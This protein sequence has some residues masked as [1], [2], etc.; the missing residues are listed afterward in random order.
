MRRSEWFRHL[1]VT[2][3]VAWTL[4]ILLIWEF[5]IF[6]IG[7]YELRSF[8]SRFQARGPTPPDPRIVLIGID[9]S[10]VL[11]DTDEDEIRDNPGY[12]WLR[13][14]PY[15]RKTYAAALKKL[16]D[17]GAKVVVF[18]LLF[19]K[20]S[21]MDDGTPEGKRLAEVDDAEFRKALEKYHDRVVIGA[22]FTYGDLGGNVA[23]AHLTMWP[24][25]NILPGGSVPNEEVV[26]FVNYVEEGDGVIR[27][28]HPVGWHPP[29]WGN[30]GDEIPYS[31]DA[32]AVKKAFPD[33]LLPKKDEQRYILFAGPNN[34]YPPVPFHLLFNTKAWKE[35]RPPLYG[36]K[37]F[38]DKIVLIGPR[39][40]FMHDD[41]F[42]PFGIGGYNKM[43]GVDIHAH[44]MAT[45]LSKNHLRELKKWQSMAVITAMG[46]L[47]GFL[48]NLPKGPL[49]KLAPAFVVGLSYWGVIQLLFEKAFLFIPFIPVEALIVG[50][51]ATVVIIQA[52]SE[53]LEKHRVSGILRK[54]VSKNVADELIRS[55][56]DAADLTKARKRTVTILFSDVRDFTTM[57]ETNEAEPFVKQLNEYLTEMV[58]CVFANG[59]TLDKFVGD[60]VM[61]VFGNPT[62]H[63]ETE[64]A[65]AAVKTATDMRKQLEELNRKWDYEGKSS[66]TIDIGI[67]HGDVMAGDL[68]SAHRKEF[69]VIGDTVNTTARI[70][71]LTK[72]LKVDIL[73]SNTV[74]DLVK[75]R[76]EAE[77]LGLKYVKGRA[78]PVDVY[79][80]KGLK[81]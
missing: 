56:G 41:H 69:G 19:T 20:P 32:L 78:K 22:N 6:K 13:D 70:E 40:N 80:L 59:G 21:R 25:S 12:A 76:L 47:F 37:L 23:A 64:D 44:A 79:A 48:L 77:H 35:N 2:V 54:Y 46:L 33:T 26:G 14:F 29:G 5:Q 49:V 50:S 66:F 57:A 15:P 39:A 43:F 73:I 61:A 9:E 51:T 72:E 45:L 27:R 16:V 60:A 17:C 24:T 68:G 28:M 18:D 10:S 67:H 74:Y 81:E 42:T 53:Q 71:S 38:K 62:S 1:P 34:I 3:T 75:E 36:G 7:N 52:V 65:W 63:G 31:L 8:D 4:A 30:N 11:N 58:D 55:H